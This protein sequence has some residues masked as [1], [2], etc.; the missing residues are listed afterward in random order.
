MFAATPSFSLMEY[1]LYMY[2]EM[3]RIEGDEKGNFAFL[4]VHEKHSIYNMIVK[5]ITYAKAQLSLKF[6]W[7]EQWSQNKWMDFILVKVAWFL[8]RQNHIA[9]HLYYNIIITL[10]V[11]KWV[12]KHLWVFYR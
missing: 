5:T 10:R 8:L 9:Q 11:C 1:I 4:L 12:S 3:I 2:D 7:N 6:V